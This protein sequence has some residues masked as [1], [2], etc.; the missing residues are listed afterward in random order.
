[1]DKKTFTYTVAVVAATQEQADEVISQR[2]YHDEDYGFPYTI[3]RV[4]T[5]HTHPQPSAVAPSVKQTQYEDLARTVAAQ[6]EAL[7]NGTYTG[8]AYGLARLLASNAAMLSAWT[9]DDRS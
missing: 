8:P 2:V 4:Y 5:E 1:M 9:A 7:A 6:A 3:D